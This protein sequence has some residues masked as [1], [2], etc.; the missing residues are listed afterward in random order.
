[1]TMTFRG[2]SRTLSALLASIA[3]LALPAAHA[4]FLEIGHDDLDID[5][6]ARRVTGAVVAVQDKPIAAQHFYVQVKP[7]GPGMQ[8]PP[9]N[10]M[11]GWRM[12][13]LAGER[14]MSVYRVVANTQDSIVLFT[15]AAQL[16]G[17][18]PG[19]VFVVEEVKPSEDRR[20]SGT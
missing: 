5:P 16:E 13:V 20:S 15:D 2:A 10:E 14:F 3:L 8:L 11:H 12:T 1:M 4:R 18:K 7:M 6:S 9:M 17:L 19:D